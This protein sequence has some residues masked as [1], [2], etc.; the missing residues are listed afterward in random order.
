MGAV[1]PNYR[2]PLQESDEL[3]YEKTKGEGFGRELPFF[4]TM[5]YKKWL[6]KQMEGKTAANRGIFLLETELGM[7]KTSYFQ[8]M[9]ENG[10][11]RKYPALQLEKTFT[12]LCDA[13]GSLYRAGETLQKV[14]FQCGKY[15]NRKFS[16][17]PVV[18]ETAQKSQRIAQQLA[19]L[20]RLIRSTT[21]N[22]RLLLIVDNIDCACDLKSRLLDYLPGEDQLDQG[23][24]IL[25]SVSSQSL[26]THEEFRK[27]LDVFPFTRKLKLDRQSF[28]YNL[29][30]K[31]I[32]SKKVLR[33]NLKHRLTDGD[34][35]IARLLK[36]IQGDYMRLSVLYA[37]MEDMGEERV[38]AFGEE[39]DILDLLFDRKEKQ[40]GTVCFH[41][42]LR[43]LVYLSL[44]Q[45]PVELSLLLQSQPVELR[46]EAAG[47]LEEFSCLLKKFYRGG[48]LY[49]SLSNYGAALYI[50]GRYGEQ[51]SL[52]CRELMQLAVER[53]TLASANEWKLFLMEK[54]YFILFNFGDEQQKSAVMQPGFLEASHNILEDICGD[55]PQDYSAVYSI[56]TERIHFLAVKKVPE[57]ETWLAKA[58]HCRERLREGA[59]DME[60]ALY[61]ENAAVHVLRQKEM[62]T[63]GEELQ[64]GEILLKRARSYAALER[65]DNAWK[66]LS[67]AIPLFEK[68]RNGQAS[69][70]IEELYLTRI[71][72]ARRSGEDS[73]LFYDYEQL[74]ALYEKKAREMKKDGQEQMG[75]K[76][77]SV[78]LER[79]NAY[80]GRGMY[81]KALRDFDQAIL[82]LIPYPSLAYSELAASA[83]GSK[84]NILMKQKK[85]RD[86]L[87]H[88]TE[89]VKIREKLYES[90][91]PEA[92]VPLARSYGNRGAALDVLGR[93]EEAFEAYQKAIAIR[94]EVFDRTSF[95]QAFGLAQVYLNRG[96]LNGKHGKIM[97][98]IMD[99]THG[100]N[101]LLPKLSKSSQKGLVLCERFYSA[102][103]TGYMKLGNSHAVQ[104]DEDKL[105]KLHRLMNKTSSQKEGKSVKTLDGT[106]QE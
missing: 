77:A 39:G 42:V 26:E 105:K 43:L 21:E 47:A 87:H 89:S 97:E 84:G 95:S 53:R 104:E 70:Q 51:A 96:I 1:G 46:E 88:F 68:H 73:C 33:L 76:I 11:G 103:K 19:E 12:L 91:E 60:G 63:D 28:T 16:V 9:A 83:Y 58:Y 13:S 93:D 98:E 29:G 5:F 49:L 15:F 81:E 37:L 66:E 55:A 45:E 99:Y 75:K 61:D 32:L 106:R 48:K 100:I 67:E 57:Q 20:L 69:E 92:G 34:M 74:L 36:L 31:K 18:L 54:T 25:V 10:M 78:Y 80:G 30:L 90:K 3:E 86:A 64:I 65:M 101:L 56:L 24:Y 59:G 38:F 14:L 94:L 40:L 102:R 27:R 22:E 6:M 44:L 79:G 4:P 41:N 71:S 85:Y 23:I 35:K 72:L 17:S 82:S 50:T 52:I 7:G 2:E 62:L 8:H